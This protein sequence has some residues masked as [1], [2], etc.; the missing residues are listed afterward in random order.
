MADN[1]ATSTALDLLWDFQV[2]FHYIALVFAVM[3]IYTTKKKCLETV[4]LLSLSYLWS[5]FLLLYQ[6][7]STP[8][9]HIQTNIIDC[10]G[11]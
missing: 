11:Y 10:I 9:R 5:S 2:K 8:N 6:D 3:I 4:F 1:G 7:I